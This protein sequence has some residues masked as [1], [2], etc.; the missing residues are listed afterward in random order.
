MCNQIITRKHTIALIFTFLL[1]SSLVMRVG[2]SAGRDAWLAILIGMVM[3]LP[4]LIVYSRIL[5]LFPGKGLYEIIF[6]SLGRFFGG[7]L[8]FLYVLY[9][10]HLGTLVMC[11]FSDFVKIVGLYETPKFVTALFLGLLCIWAV[12]AGIEVIARWTAITMPIMVSVILLITLLLIPKFNFDNLRPVL[13]N[14]MQPVLEAAF[15]VFSFPFAESVVCLAIFSYVKSGSKPLTIF[16]WSILAGT[17][18]LLVTTVRSLLVL[19][20]EFVKLNFF[21]S[22]ASAR[23]I[24]IGDF[25]ERIEVLVAIVILIG[26]FVKIS[27]CLLTAAKGI[28]DLANIRDYGQFAAPLGI[29]MALYSVVLFES[30]V[31]IFI[32]SEKVYQYYALPFQVLFPLIIWI[33]A[34]IKA[35]K[36]IQGKAK[37]R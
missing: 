26:G 1:G 21:A 16:M 22:Y 10:F 29:L 18:I 33:A 23:L 25:L 32:W 4:M 24:K 36:M 8:V 20:E 28:A 27:I 2:G 12:K 14:G 6:T 13:Y 11:D 30:T 15:S 37:R 7:V 31:E 3:T 35:K 17:L 9:S 5:S 19:G 34:E